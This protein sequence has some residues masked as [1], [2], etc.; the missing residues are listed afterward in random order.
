MSEVLVFMGRND[1]DFH[2]VNDLK[3][4]VTVCCQ[5]VI[6]N[7]SYPNEPDLYIEDEKE[8]ECEICKSK[9]KEFKVKNGKYI[10]LD[11]LELFYDNSKYRQ[12]YKIGTLVT[13]S[14]NLNWH[15]TKIRTYSNHFHQHVETEMFGFEGKKAIIVGK[16]GHFNNGKYHA[17]SYSLNIYPEIKWSKRLFSK[18]LPP[19]DDSMHS[20]WCRNIQGKLSSHRDEVYFENIEYT[21]RM[22]ER[23]RRAYNQMDR[24]LIARANKEDVRPDPWAEIAFLDKLFNDQ[25]RYRY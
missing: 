21:K 9:L 24:A 8:I 23:D 4:K 15:E 22:E 1:H 20:D 13:I 3:S 14:D 19:I 10:W 12:N 7:H 6:G 5:K 16:H 25:G 2:W 11:N 17:N 18:F